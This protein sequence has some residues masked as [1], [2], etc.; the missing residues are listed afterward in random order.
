MRMTVPTLKG[1]DDI[2]FTRKFLQQ[3]LT[4]LSERLYRCFGRQVRLVVH[5]GAVMAR[6][7]QPSLYHRESTQDVDY[8]HVSFASEYRARLSQLTNNDC[9]SASR[10]PLSNS[11]L[12]ADWINDQCRCGASPVPPTSPGPSISPA[13]CF[14]RELMR[15]RATRHIYFCRSRTPVHN[16]RPRA[17][18]PMGP[19]CCSPSIATRQR[20]RT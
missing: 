11:N 19:T 5:R 6:V 15:M 18:L 9:V 3:V 13:L 1:I 14:T 4:E 10:R 2:L 20:N 8:I 16:H 7:L 17:A 12:G